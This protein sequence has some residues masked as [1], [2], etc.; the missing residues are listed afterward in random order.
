MGKAI[1]EKVKSKECFKGVIHP[2]QNKQPVVL[3]AQMHTY[4]EHNGND[5]LS[6]KALKE[7]VK[8]VAPSLPRDPPPLK[9]F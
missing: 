5:S 7:P 4:S 1:V 3:S 2:S 9:L 6:R 8:T